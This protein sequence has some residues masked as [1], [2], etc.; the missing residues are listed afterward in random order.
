[1]ILV[2]NHFVEISPG[3]EDAEVERVPLDEV[4]VDEDREEEP[5]TTKARDQAKKGQ[6]GP[7]QAFETVQC[8]PL[9]IDCRKPAL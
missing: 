7:R 9:D 4:V 8:N 3:V 2:A 5:M 1:L 6:G